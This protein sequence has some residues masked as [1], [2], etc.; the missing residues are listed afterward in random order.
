[1]FA[2]D[3]E[4]GDLWKG[5]RRIKLQ[6]QP[7]Q[8]LK[9]LLSRPGELVTR[10]ELRRKLWP[11]D[12]FVD[13]DNGLNVVIRKIREALGDVTPSPR[14]VETEKAQGYRFI[15][16]L[17]DVPTQPDIESPTAS[18]RLNPQLVFAAVALAMLAGTSIWLWRTNVLDS[19][20]S[21]Q[22]RRRDRGL[23]GGGHSRRHHHAPV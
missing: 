20:P 12:T 14:F 6:N 8:V 2:F 16:P 19:A 22:R 21:R 23:S 15:A 5:S 13:F 9:L 10:E 3:L 17:S 11:G 7:R 4:S 18:S 1:V